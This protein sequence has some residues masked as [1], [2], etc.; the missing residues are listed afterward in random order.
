MCAYTCPAVPALFRQLKLHLGFF[1]FGELDIA[2]TVSKLP[3]PCLVVIPAP[4]GWAPWVNASDLVRE[5]GEGACVVIDAAQTAFGAVDFPVPPGG[6]VLS[7]PRKTMAIGDGALLAVEQFLESEI[8]ELSHLTRLDDQALRKQ[9]VRQL[10]AA[11][12]ICLEKEALELDRKVESEWGFVPHAASRGSMTL[13]ARAD[14]A[15]HRKIRRDNAKRLAKNLSSRVELIVPKR[16]WEAPDVPFSFPLLH[17]DR[18]LVIQRLHAVRVF[19]TALWPTTECD[20]RSQPRAADLARRLIALPV[21]Q[22]YGASDMDRMTE[23][24]RPCL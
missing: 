2:G 6:A 4:F 9:E 8:N 14:W 1:D 3:R 10:F 24:V 11:G 13:I 22:R 16:V 15:A 12:D 19:A 5:L 20:P 23:L 7:C 18:D 21:D 17:E